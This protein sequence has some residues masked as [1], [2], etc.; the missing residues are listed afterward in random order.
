MERRAAPLDPALR[1]GLE[2]PSGEGAP[3]PRLAAAEAEAAGFGT[4]WLDG[5]PLD[6]CTLAGALVPAT[7]S[8]LLGV[9]AGT[10]PGQRAPSVLARDVTA[11]DVVSSGR[12]AV[13]LRGGDVDRLA[14]AVVVCRLM[15]RADAPTYHGSSFTIVGAANRPPPVRPAGPPLLVEVPPGDRSPPAARHAAALRGADALVVR[16]GPAEVAAWRAAAGGTPVLWRGELEEPGGLPALAAAGASG[17]VVRV[18]AATGAWA[19]VV[20]SWAATLAAL[21]PVPG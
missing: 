20:R 15:F 13:L 14:E 4:V 19:E 10:G 7:G 1:L 21:W 9:V 12:A 8:V 16:G 6:P 2:V 11:L 5:G 18:P 3:E 17:A